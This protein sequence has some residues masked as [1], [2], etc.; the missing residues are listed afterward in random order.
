MENL[1]LCCKM[2]SYIQIIFVTLSLIT[3]FV[4]GSWF[5][6]INRCNH[7]SMVHSTG[8][9]L[10]HSQGTETNHKKL[11]IFNAGQKLL[12]HLQKMTLQEKLSNTTI[13]QTPM[14]SPLCLVNCTCYPWCAILFWQ[15]HDQAVTGLSLHATGDVFVYSLFWP[16]NAVLVS[17]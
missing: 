7:P 2:R 3:N 9:L 12:T 8:I 17:L 6:W 13:P 15:A 11:Y 10:A 5:H 14:S 16:R 1:G 4:L